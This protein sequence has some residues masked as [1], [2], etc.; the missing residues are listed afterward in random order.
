MEPENQTKPEHQKELDSPKRV[1][2]TRNRV[3]NAQLAECLRN[4]DQHYSYQRPGDQNSQR[5]A[6]TESLTGSAAKTKT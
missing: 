6:I 4:I 2:T 3:H 5:S 1:K